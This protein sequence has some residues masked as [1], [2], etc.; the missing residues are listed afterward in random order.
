MR[1]PAAWLFACAIALAACEKRDPVTD[2]AD[3]AAGLPSIAKPTP[4]ADGSAPINVATKPA[5]PTGVPAPAVAIPAA[6]HGRWSLT[7]ADC[8]TTRGD[9]KGLLVV[10][11]DRLQFY[12]SRAVPSRNVE[13][14]ND[15]ISADFA[16][17]GEGQAWTK[18]Q[19]LTLEDG[20]LVRTESNP[21]ASFTYARCR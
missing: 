14:S 21:M 20:K 19:A 5:D 9:A 18:Y 1:I 13:S 16:F 3:N 10:T 8:T 12:E 15:S 4:T 6:L 11:G 17:T 7:P 2:E